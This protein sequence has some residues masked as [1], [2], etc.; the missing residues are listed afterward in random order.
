MGMCS[1]SICGKTTSQLRSVPVTPQRF[2][3][4][5]C[6]KHWTSLTPEFFFF[7]VRFFFFGRDENER[8]VRALRGTS[9]S[10][11]LGLKPQAPQSNITWPHCS[12]RHTADPVPASLRDQV[13]CRLCGTMWRT[14]SMAPPEK[15]R[16]RPRMSWPACVSNVVPKL[17]RL[18]VSC[19]VG[20][21]VRGQWLSDHVHRFFA[22]TSARLDG[23][24]HQSAPLGCGQLWG[25]LL[26]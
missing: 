17:T 5:N 13:P 19:T 14:I 12:E 4:E 15:W 10:L 18:G 9:L 7:L 24:D 23:E 21:R 25:K 1:T 6:G 8:S 16:K 22:P 11:V 2:E 3:P 26:P 20:H